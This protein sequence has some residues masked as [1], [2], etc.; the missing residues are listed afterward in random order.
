MIRAVRRRAIPALACLAVLAGLIPA[1]AAEP[2]MTTGT[3]TSFDGA[4]ILYHLFT[5]ADAS[6]TSR[7]PII[8]MTHGWGGSGQTSYDGDVALLIDHGYAV[9]TWDQRGFGSSGGEANVD[10]QE[11]E[12]RDVQALIDFAAARPEIQ[13]DAPGDPRMGMLG[14]SYAGGIQLMTAAADGRVDAIAPDIAWNDLP[15][16]IFPRGINKL[17]WD[18]ALYGLGTATGTAA[19]LPA[20]ETGG[21]AFEIHKALIEGAVLNEV[22]P[23]SV[24]WFDARSPKNYIN[25]A[26]L[27][28]GTVVPGIKVPTLLTQG[29]IDTLFNLNQAIYNE[30][31]I[32]ANGVPTKM[33]FFCGGHAIGGGRACQTGD[34]SEHIDDAVLA[35]FDR[36]VREQAAVDTG[37]AIEYQLQ[38]GTFASVST[39]PAT[40]ATADGAGMVVNTIVPTSG[41]PLQAGPAPD[42]FRVPVAIPEGA[43]LLGIPTATVSVTGAG[44]DAG[45]FFKLI[46]TASGSSIA[47][48]DQVSPLRIKNLSTTAQ[49]FT[50][51]LT[52]VAW[53]VEAGHAIAV[54]VSATSLDHSSIRTPFLA[55]VAMSVRLPYVPAGG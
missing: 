8:F 37:P 18:L 45:L 14:G 3:V 15:F 7:V 42:G 17:G 48:D 26:T 28:D 20:G 4:S 16:A 5:P 19:G 35:W 46:D 11:F 23:E 22:S 6:A 49:T 1:R 10:A 40:A 41:T 24:A 39:L 53:L 27:A 29:T 25:G 38:D 21:L 54:E 12:V 31:Q 9:L 33:I 30:R 13:L 44:P 34:M 32:A 36:Y 50:I 2:A 43:H 55:N 47:I 52:A 51:D